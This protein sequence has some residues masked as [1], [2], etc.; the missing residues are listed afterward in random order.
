MQ[1]GKIEFNREDVTLP[2]TKFHN[3][4]AEN[5]KKIVK[6]SKID[7]IPSGDSYEDKGYG[8]LLLHL[9]L[10]GTKMNNNN[11]KRVLIF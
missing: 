8:N 11:L 2:P 4:F 7:Q 6:E 10:Q 1:N 9:S 3:D 5:I